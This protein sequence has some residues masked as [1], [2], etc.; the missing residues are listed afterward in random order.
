MRSGEAPGDG[1]R[2]GAAV[3]D[4][5]VGDPLYSRVCQAVRVLTAARRAAIYLTSEALSDT[6][7][8]EGSDR[9]DCALYPAAAAGLPFA[10]LVEVHS[11]ARVGSPELISTLASNS[12][13]ELRPEVLPEPYRR[14]L[15]ISTVVCVPVAVARRRFGAIFAEFEGAAR[16]LE[17][18][19][20]PRLVGI[21][22]VAAL[23]ACSR[24]PEHGKRGRD[25]SRSGST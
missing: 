21:A 18:E 17:A 7:S 5:P 3:R 23:A 1:D 11:D 2:G 8:V 4:P 15:G 12:P 19:D 22:K 20:T 13:T 24:L 9:G 16:G 10:R 14:S 6:V 25:T